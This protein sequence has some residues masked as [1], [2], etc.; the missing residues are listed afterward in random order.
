MDTYI[1]NNNVTLAC[2]TAFQTELLAGC[3][4]VREMLQH[5]GTGV[6]EAAGT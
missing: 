4:Q 6:G 1:A 3:S 5:T 2:P